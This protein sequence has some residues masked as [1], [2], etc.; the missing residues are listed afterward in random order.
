MASGLCRRQD[1]PVPRLRPGY[2]VLAV[3]L[4]AAVAVGGTG[5]LLLSRH[6]TA[7]LAAVADRQAL[8]VSLQARLIDLELTRLVGEVQRLSQLAE[9][10]LA[11]DNLEPEK[12]VLR[13]ARRDTVLFSVAILV[14]DARGDVLWSEPRGAM[15]GTDGAALVGEA[16]GRGRA[17]LSLSPG[18]IDVAAPIAGRGAI[19][20]QVSARSRDLFGEGLHRALGPRGGLALLRTGA[21]ATFPIATAGAALTPELAAEGGQAWREDSKGQRWLVTESRVGEAPLLLRLAQPAAALEAEVDPPLRTLAAIVGGALL[22]AALGG[23][24]LARA[25]AR[26]E[27]AEAEL[28]RSRDLADMGKTA[29]AIAHEVKNSLNGLSIALDLLASGKAPPAAAGAVH[30]QARAELARL[31]GVADD[32]TLFASPPRLDLAEVDLVELC[33]RAGATCA[34]L[35]LDCESEVEL[36][37]PSAGT[38]VLVRA[39]GHKLL[40]AM[41]NLVRNGLEAMGPGGFGEPLG[42]PPPQGERRLL[43]SLRQARRSAV[44]EIADRG[45]GLA[46]EVRERLF[47]PFVSTKRTGTGLGLAI[48]RR[49]VEAHGG[50]IGARDREGGGTVFRLE[51]PLAVAARAPAPAESPR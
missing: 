21:G 20:G 30:A 40:G 15:L 26:L 37:L 10:D 9:V 33:R 46:P 49:V 43:L 11:D 44:V 7:A 22:F 16:R 12:G 2:L 6:R 23:A 45:P 29:A 8:L 27:K 50:G 17:V 24:L 51:L 4:F 34:D 31:R 14:L 32:L 47:E 38:P 5:A 42:A 18:E 1:R 48:A 35:A 25:L 41:A 13:I 19:A 39:D 3:T 36:E 28:G